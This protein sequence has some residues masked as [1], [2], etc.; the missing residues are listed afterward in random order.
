[1]SS[2]FYICQQIYIKIYNGDKNKYNIK[3]VTRY[4][5]QFFTIYYTSFIFCKF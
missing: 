4:H 5:R 1:M 3:I 2:L